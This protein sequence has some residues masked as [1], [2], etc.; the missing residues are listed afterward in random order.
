LAL[1]S[2]AIAARL[3]MDDVVPAGQSVRFELAALTTTPI[4]S[5]VTED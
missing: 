4:S 3:S 5:T 1:Y 2:D